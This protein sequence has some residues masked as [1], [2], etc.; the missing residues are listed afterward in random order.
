M[1]LTMVPVGTGAALVASGALMYAASWQRWAGACPWGQ[2]QDT[3]ACTV[4][5]DHLYDFLLPTEP[6]RPVGSAAELAG[7]SLLVLA[8]ALPF[9]TTAV[10]GRRPGAP[11]V[12][13]L[14][15]STLAVVDVGVATLRSGLTGEVVGPVGDDL[16][17]WLW[18]CLPLGVLA[19]LAVRGRGWARVGAILLVLGAPLVAAFSYGLGSF[20]TAPWWEAVS[21]ILTGAGGICVLAAA[22][23]RP[24]RR[25][26][27]APEPVV[28]R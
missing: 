25:R 9:L 18:L 2:D 14:L 28:A 27:R 3:V 17:L 21:G 19:V 12:A 4:R 24:G 10:A 1:G 15:V 7:A 11:A 6:W 5:Q 16:S 13:A 22:V 26:E 23:R 8:L 20:D